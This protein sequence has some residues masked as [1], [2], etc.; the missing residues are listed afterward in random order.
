MGPPSLRAKRA[1]DVTLA[2][3]GLSLLAPLLP[4]VALAIRLEGGGPVLHRDRR[5]GVQRRAPR[6]PERG[7]SRVH[8]V[9]G[10]LFSL[11][12]FRV[13]GER[14][15]VHGRRPGEHPRLTHVG[16]LLRRTGLEGW[17]QL[18]NVLAGQMSLVG[19][20]AAT[21]QCV[22]RL[23]RECPAWGARTSHVPPGVFGFAQLDRPVGG[24]FFAAACEKLLFDMEY[25]R[26]LREHGPL[27]ILIDDLGIMLSSLRR[28]VSGRARSAGNDLIRIDYPRTWRQVALDGQV[29]ARS[30]PAGL[31]AEV[32]EEDQSLVAYWYPPRH[33]AA[34]RPAADEAA[35]EQLCDRVDHE[36]GESLT[37]TRSLRPSG[38]A[39]S[40]TMTLELPTSLHEV[41]A[42]CEHLASLWGA[43]AARSDDPAF[44]LSMAFLV[45]EGLATVAGA[46]DG[47]AQRVVLT[48]E[49]GADELRINLEPRRRAGARVGLASGVRL[50]TPAA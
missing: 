25:D 47:Q 5:V 21:P 9:R 43:L 18:L 41:H 32:V 42:V 49:V 12:R 13:L 28:L 23:A 17:P 29:L 31:G 15:L 14:V 27:R 3:L 39:G 44:P 11:L 8:D 7:G 26:R 19:P 46:L 30:T 10:R 20:R 48:I 2:V 22:E 37:L 1:L 45:V 16:R 4:F 35:L 50:P 36:P 38:T 24:G 33:V 40:D 34:L 6:S